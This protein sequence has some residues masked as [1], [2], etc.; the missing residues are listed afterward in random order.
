M[1][2]RKGMTR[3]YLECEELGFPTQVWMNSPSL[4]FLKRA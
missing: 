3:D 4:E 1:F 2:T